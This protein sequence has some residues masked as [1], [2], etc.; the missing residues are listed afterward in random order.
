MTT[1]EADKLSFDIREEFRDLLPPAED[2]R[3]Q[4][5]VASIRSFGVLDPLKV[6]DETNVLL[7]GHRRVSI[8]EDNPELIE[9]HGDPEVVRLSFASS[10]EAKA[11]MIGFQNCRRSVSKVSAAITEGLKVENEQGKRNDLTCYN[12]VT[13]APV[14]D[15]VERTRNKQAAEGW[16]EVA[17]SNPEAAQS[18]IGDP[19]TKVTQKDLRSIATAPEESRPAKVDEVVAKATGKPHVTNNSGENEWYTPPHVLDVARRVLGDIALDPAS[20][21]VAQQNVQA[22]RFYSVKENGLEQEW[23]ADSVWMNPPYGQPLIKEFVEKFVHEYH[24]GH[25]NKAC[26]LVNNG[27]ETVWFQNLASQADA[28]CFIRGRLKFLDSTGSPANTPLQ[29][30]ALLY[31]G[32]ERSKFLQE[33]ELLGIVTEMTSR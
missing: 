24:E 27:T 21:E 15:R 18:I 3:N 30:Q 2:W 20:C 26:V 29:G 7:D 19:E 10:G 6:W 25:F 14:G 32:D 4:E 16:S 13:S 31:F 23:Y 5:L 12:D 33:A 28:I 1:Q 9:R 22:H 8:L 11:W 17:K